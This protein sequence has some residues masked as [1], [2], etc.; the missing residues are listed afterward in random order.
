MK[1]E[2]LNIHERINVKSWVRNDIRILNVYQFVLKFE[3]LPQPFAQNIHTPCD[4]ESFLF[5]RNWNRDINPQI[6]YVPEPAPE[7]LKCD[8]TNEELMKRLE[9]IKKKY[10]ENLEKMEPITLFGK[11]E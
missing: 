9:E 1:Y 11:N 2:D 3:H 5:R 8:L 6:V 7:V 4:T 10:G